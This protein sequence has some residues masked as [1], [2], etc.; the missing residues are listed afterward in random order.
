MKSFKIVGN[1]TFTPP[2]GRNS[3]NPCSHTVVEDWDSGVGV[4]QNPLYRYKAMWRHFV[5]KHRHVVL[6]EDK[7]TFQKRN[8]YM[9]VWK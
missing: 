9:R 4:I 8:R 3:R 1:L 7:V 2:K 6:V 5:R